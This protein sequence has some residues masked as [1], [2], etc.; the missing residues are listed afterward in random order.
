MSKVVNKITMSDAE[1]FGSGTGAA[2]LYQDMA[3]SLAVYPG[4]GTAVGLM[5]VALKLNGEAGE[6]AE[7]V[8]KALRDD[9]LEVNPENNWELTTD[10]RDKL[11][12]EIGDV[13]WYCAAACRELGIL[14][15]DA[16]YINLKKLADRSER[17]VLQGS[18]DDR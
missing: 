16:M 13:L 4:Q 3:T 6:F 18:G 8:G 11:I 5:Y 9:G 17:G 2:D 7:H 14:M 1:R 15:S 12:K 10:R